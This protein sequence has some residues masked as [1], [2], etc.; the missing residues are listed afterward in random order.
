MKSTMGM[1]LTGGKNDRLKEL[2]ELRSSTAVPIGGK[3][4]VID[5][6]LSNMVN[7]GITNIG[8]LTQ[9]SFRSLMDHLG[10]GKEWD[11]DR[12]NDGLFIFPPYLAGEHSGWYQG[13]ADAMYHNITFL[14]RSFEEYIVVA[15]G[16]CVYKM[17]FDD[18]L[19]YHIDKKADITIAYRDMSD[20]PVEE[21][22]FMGVMKMD[23]NGRVVDFKEKHNHPESTIC[24]MG[25]YILR[26]ELLID[27]LEECNSL[28]KYDFVKDVIISK[29]NTLQIYGYRFNGYWR[30]LNTIN[31]YYRI[32]MEMLNPE[33]RHQLFEENGKV[34]TKVK[35]EPPA[36]YNEEA[37]VSNSIIADGCIVEGTVS[38]SVLFRGVTIKKNAVVNGCIIMQGSVIDED[39][40]IENSII[41][42]NVYISK[43]INLKGMPNFPIMIEKNAKI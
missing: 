37:E 19:N 17:L 25:I 35:D 1:I 42:K 3:Y 20:F 36:K 13:S 32:N 15:Q 26:R 6:V 39:V 27:L 18:M 4:R 11:L 41:D 21:L 14:K 23:D 30:N 38:N 2:A 34:Y 29:L 8:V 16:N 40:K 43:G 31:A 24:S 28:G 22:S 33:I 10:S 7:S 12:R 9:Y 5:F